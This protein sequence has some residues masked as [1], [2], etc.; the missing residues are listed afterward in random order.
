[1][2]IV[3]DPE[4]SAQNERE[5]GLPFERVA[6]LDWSKAHTVLDNRHDYG[7]QRMIAVAPL[8]GRLQS[9]S[10]RSTRPRAPHYQFPQS[11][12]ARGSALMP[13]SARP[14]FTDETGE[15][16]ELIAD[17][18]KQMRPIAEV[19]PGMVE[20]IDTWRHRLKGRPKVKA[21]K[22]HIGFRLAADVVDGI[23]GTG[24]GYNALG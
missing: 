5:R 3:F 14:S 20:A 23:K 22:V 12:Q 15:V 8:N 6:E 19:D 11:K 16:R 13:K 24:K 7:E 1:M 4:K 18:F 10:L 9:V 17:D 2:E 21:P